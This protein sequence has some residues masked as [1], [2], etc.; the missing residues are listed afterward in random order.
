M[1]Y[2]GTILVMTHEEAKS[3]ISLSVQEGYLNINDAEKLEALPE[4]EMIR[5]VEK[6]AE[7]GDLQIFEDSNQE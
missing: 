4:E 2:Y 5:E 6:L 7:R 1:C 3:Y